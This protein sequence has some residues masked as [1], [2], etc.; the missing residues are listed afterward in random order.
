MMVFK[1][2]SGLM[3]ETANNKQK[4]KTEIQKKTVRFSQRLNQTLSTNQYTVAECVRAH[5]LLRVV[6]GCIERCS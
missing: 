1:Q 3:S 2:F 5:L 4:K 6:S